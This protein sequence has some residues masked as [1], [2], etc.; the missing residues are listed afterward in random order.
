MNPSYAPRRLLVASVPHIQSFTWSVL[1]DQTLFAETKSGLGVIL[2]DCH[3]YLRELF[4]NVAFEPPEGFRTR[5]LRLVVNGIKPETPFD[6]FAV[7]D[8]DLS[9]Q[10]RILSQVG[11]SIGYR[12]DVLAGWRTLAFNAAIHF[13]LGPCVTVATDG[14]RVVLFSRPR[15]GCDYTIAHRRNVNGP[16]T[17]TPKIIEDWNYFERKSGVTVRRTSTKTEKESR[18]TKLKRLLLND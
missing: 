12:L 5:S 1:E 11:D 15:F 7:S 8:D 3:K 16:V 4:D 10:S 18:E 17:S 6:R 9:S 2:G 14:S 13:Q